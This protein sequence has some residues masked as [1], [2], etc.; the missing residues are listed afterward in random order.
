MR[1]AALS[2]PAL[3]NRCKTT[4]LAFVADESLRGSMPFPRFGFILLHV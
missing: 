3:L 2:L 4:L 1:L